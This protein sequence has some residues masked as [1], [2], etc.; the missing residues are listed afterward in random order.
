MQLE[1]RNEKE[2]KDYIEECKWMFCGVDNKLLPDLKQGR[3]IVQAAKRIN[4]RFGKQYILCIV[5]NDVFKQVEEF[6]VWSNTKIKEKLQEAE[7]LNLIDVAENLLYLQ[8]DNLGTLKITEQNCNM[9]GNKTVYY[10]L[11]LNVK[12]EEEE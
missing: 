4:N 7:D 11:I 2:K 10:N 5:E 6:T 3:Y 12:E 9:Y 1:L 8:K